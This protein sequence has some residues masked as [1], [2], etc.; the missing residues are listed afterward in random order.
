MV[1]MNNFS[2]FYGNNELY[3]TG[4]VVCVCP[5]GKQIY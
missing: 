2:E 5:L 3:G 1:K 4:E